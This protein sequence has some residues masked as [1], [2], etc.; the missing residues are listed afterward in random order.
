[1]TKKSPFLHNRLKAYAHALAFYR[2]AKAVRAQMPRGHA[3]LND[4]LV[5]ASS[6]VCLNLAEG[7]AAFGPGIKR[8]YFRIALAS[9]GECAAVL[10]LI[11]IEGACDVDLLDRARN[12]IRTTTLITV[13][14]VR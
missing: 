13:G 1:M 6:S 5:R 10:D 3:E 11:D 12:L 7:A 14:L 2:V 9:A 4:Q 8:R